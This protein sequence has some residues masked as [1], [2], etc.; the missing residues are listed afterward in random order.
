MIQCTAPKELS[1]HPFLL[2]RRL[3]LLLRGDL[4]VRDLLVGIRVGSRPVL[5]GRRL[6]ERIENKLDISINELI[7]G[8][9]I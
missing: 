8:S 7:R 2:E 4:L 9:L 1:L 5:E 6:E 3:N